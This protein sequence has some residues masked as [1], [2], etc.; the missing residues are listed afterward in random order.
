VLDTPTTSVPPLASNGSGTLV[1]RPPLPA[2][3]GRR[4]RPSPLPTPR[5]PV[6]EW[7][8][9]TLQ[10]GGPARQAA[11][12]ATDDP[13]DGED[14]HIA[15]AALYE[16]AYRGLEGVDEERE[17]DLDLL[18]L[19]LALEGRFTDALRQAIGPLPDV[20]DVPAFLQDF[21]TP[22]TGPSVSRHCAASPDL[23]QFQEQSVHRAFWQ[24]KEADP[25]SWAIPRLAGRPKAALV[26][27]QADEY[28]DGVERDIHAELYALTMER[29]GLSS[30][31][32][33]YLEAWP[34]CTLATVNLVSMFGMRRRWLGA[35]TGHLAVFEM[36]STTT[37]GSFATALRALGFDTWTCLFYDT[38]VVAD[39]HHQTVAAHELVGGLLEQQPQ[40]A[41]DVVFG[42]LAIEQVEGRLTE[43]LLGAWERGESSL[44]VPV[45]LPDPAPG[46][47]VTPIPADDPRI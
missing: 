41:P 28:G 3:A 11:P 22:G 25:H 35:L 8:V 10:R 12:T 37:M 38:H 24:L 9:E 40:R 36:T 42:A 19:R 33:E 20:D 31:Y 13:I 1:D 6:S 16:L 7:L 47:L 17:W 45:D 14:T 5:G 26:E 34:G 44:R 39:A 46:Q 15:L 2:L 21:T 27:I 4:H 29:L 32:N 18:A 23:R 30:A 43:H